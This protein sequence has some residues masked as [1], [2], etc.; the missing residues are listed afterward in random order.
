M[1]KQNKNQKIKETLIATKNRHSKMKVKTFEVKV[2]GSKLSCEQKKQINQ[3]FKEAKW[4]RNHF[5]AD[6]DNADYKIN[7]VN[8]KVKNGVET[9]TLDILGSQVKQ[10]ILK[11]LKSEIKGLSTT[12]SKGKKI[13]KLKFKSVCN[14]I[15]LKQFGTTYKIDFS[16]NR[17]KIQNIKKALYVRGLKQIPGDADITNAKFVRKPDGLYFYITCY[18]LKKA[19]TKTVM[20]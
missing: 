20:K 19:Y 16:K 18:V 12:K 15:P 10:D 17:I 4:L 14:S 11:N 2:V 7:V 1:D 13:G 8:V 6:L 5:L 3:Y 9:R